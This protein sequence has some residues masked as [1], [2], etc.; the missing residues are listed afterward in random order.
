MQFKPLVQKAT[1][2]IAP[3]ILKLQKESPKFLFVAGVIGVGA[4]VVLACRA[5]M[6]MDEILQEGETNRDNIEKASKLG[7]D[8]YTEADKKQDSALNRYKTGFKIVKMYAPAFA[9]GVLSIAALSGSHIILTR[10]N[11]GLTAAYV[12]VDRGFREYRQRVVDELGPQK[13][14]EFRYGATDKEIGVETDEGVAIK[15]VRVLNPGGQ[16]SMYAKMFDETCRNWQRGPLMYNHTFLQAQQQYARDLLE[17]RGHVFLNEIYTALGMNHT[18]AGSQVGW[19]RKNHPNANENTSGRIDFGVFV[20]EFD[21]IGFMNGED[22]KIL[23]DPNV[24]GVIW[25]LIDAKNK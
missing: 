22:N 14:L 9:V 18:S 8:D 13:D 5:T 1:N 10:R 6:Q 2:K 20:N 25:D 4:T 12:A 17:V 23:I 3:Q 16:P 19:L 7:R 21:G 15:T 24:D 11:T